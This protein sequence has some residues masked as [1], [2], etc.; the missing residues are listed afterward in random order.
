MDQKL[1]QMFS[2]HPPPQ[3]PLTETSSKNY[4]KNMNALRNAALMEVNGGPSKQRLDQISDKLNGMRDLG[5][6]IAKY[7]AIMFNDDVTSGS[8]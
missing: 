5:G 8:S 3:V 7:E 2:S 4:E 6:N 1:D